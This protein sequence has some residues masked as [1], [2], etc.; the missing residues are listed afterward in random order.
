MK[1][2]EDLIGEGAASRLKERYGILM[3]YIGVAEQGPQMLKMKLQVMNYKSM[4][5]CPSCNEKERTL[6][7]GI[8]EIEYILYSFL[9]F[10]E[11]GAEQ[12]IH[13]NNNLPKNGIHM[14]RE[15]YAELM[16]SEREA[17]R[18][19]EGRLERK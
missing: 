19:I 1:R 14:H 8:A 17:M 5:A 11:R 9:N 2:I 16:E 12:V 15:I 4:S 13:C 10:G 18:K 6:G 7:I 3:D